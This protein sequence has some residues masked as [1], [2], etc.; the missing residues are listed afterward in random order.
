MFYQKFRTGLVP[1]NLKPRPYN[2]DGPTSLCLSI[3]TPER[4]TSLHLRGLGAARLARSA[5][6]VSPAAACRGARPGQQLHACELGQGGR[7]SVRASS[8]CCEPG[9][10]L[11]SWDL[12]CALF[13]LWNCHR[14]RD[15][16]RCLQLFAGERHRAIAATLNSSHT[17]QRVLPLILLLSTG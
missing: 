10:C 3:A 12:H 2:W 14:V 9:L 15:T 4:E 11:G 7:S 8:A 17:V 13:L 1:A 16:S 5:A 6:A